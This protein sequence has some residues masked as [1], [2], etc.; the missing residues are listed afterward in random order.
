M[1][2]KDKRAIITAAASG[3][4]RAGCEVFAR[5]GATVFAVDMDE[6]RLN[7]VV[8]SVEAAGGKAYGLVAD[9]LD[10]EVCAHVIEEA[11]ARMG[12][13]DVLWNHAGIP[14]L[15][16]IESLDLAEYAKSM[17]LN[18]RTGLIMTGKA[19][20]HLRKQGGGSVIFTASTAGLVGASVS[21]V[22]SAAKFA[23]VGMGKSLALRYATEKIRV[24]VVCPGPIETPMFPQFFDP[25][26]S[27]EMAAEAQARTIAAI[28]MAR[29]GQAIEVAHAALWLA[30]DDAS[31]VT[32]V[33]LP[34]D[35][36]Y[37]A[38]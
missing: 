4:G 22:Y 19:I 20:P 3:M 25:K 32:G 17:D 15:R 12:G 36:G 1:R 35:G 23:V 11:A 37:T 6:T 34:V 24:N 18:I 38:R 30:S 27:K 29:M 5:E 10:P 7:D 26:A 2:L 16:D 9:L 28:P 13:I 14:G 21:P 31:F 8:K 33:A